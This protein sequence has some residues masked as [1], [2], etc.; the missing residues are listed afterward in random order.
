M[1]RMFAAVDAH[2]ENTLSCA[3]YVYIIAAIFSEVVARYG[4]GSS[5]L[6]LEETAI[7]VFIWLTYISMANLAKTRSH[8]AFTAIRDALPPPVQLALLLLADI[9]LL[10]LS[11]IIIIYIYQP[12]ADSILFEQQMM[13]ANLPLWWA[14]AAVP[15]GWILVTI[16]VIQRAVVSIKKY[17]A[18]EPLVT[19]VLAIE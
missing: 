13:G 19:G 6:W 4:L 1:R 7:Y 2:L 15:F 12:I 10:I 16:R 17:R 3:L 8:L 18:G 14:T 5:V 9:C 11:V